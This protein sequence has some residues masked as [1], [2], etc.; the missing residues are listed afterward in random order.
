MHI[1]RRATRERGTIEREKSERERGRDSERDSK[2][3]G[4]RE[5]DDGGGASGRDMGAAIRGRRRP[6]SHCIKMRCPRGEQGWLASSGVAAD[7]GNAP[8]LGHFQD[9]W[10]KGPLPM[11]HV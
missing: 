3:H 2:I 10:C 1:R 5:K 9:Y 11:D 7:G 4:E 8:H 6:S